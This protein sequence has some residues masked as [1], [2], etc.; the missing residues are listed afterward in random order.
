[1]AG[2]PTKVSLFDKMLKDLNVCW[3]CGRR[4]SL[5]FVRHLELFDP[6]STSMSFIKHTS[7]PLDNVCCNGNG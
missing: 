4:K 3:G 6:E 1:M 7:A 2:L 5:H